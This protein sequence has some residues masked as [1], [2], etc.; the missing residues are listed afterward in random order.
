MYLLV[1]LL[2]LAVFK[3]I[4]RGFLQKQGWDVSSCASF[5]VLSS[6]VV[7]QAIIYS[8]AVL[9]THCLMSGL[10]SDMLVL[11]FV[12]FVWCSMGGGG[13]NGDWWWPHFLL[14]GMYLTFLDAQPWQVSILGILGIL[15]MLT[16]LTILAIL[17][18]RASGMSA[19]AAHWSTPCGACC[20]TLLSGAPRNRR[21]R[22]LHGMSV[23]LP[24]AASA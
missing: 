4:H 6:L 22:H 15:A 14:A 8:D 11:V 19:R 18:H 10:V 12:V 17:T 7:M 13:G 5:A 24:L 16:I 20:G 21:S 23:S 1:F 3:S 9:P 2:L